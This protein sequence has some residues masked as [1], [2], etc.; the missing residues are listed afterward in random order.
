[1]VAA[2]PP[3]RAVAAWAAVLGPGGLLRCHVRAHASL[4]VADGDDLIPQPTWMVK[5]RGP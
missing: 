4:Q 1:L 3:G 5:E 2:G